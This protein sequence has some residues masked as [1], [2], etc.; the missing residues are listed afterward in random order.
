MYVAELLE[1]RVRQLLGFV[2]DQHRHLPLMAVQVPH[3]VVELAPGQG[4][5]PPGRHAE[6]VQYLR[7]EVGRMQRRLRQIHHRMPDRIQLRGQLA[8]RGGLAGANVARDDPEC[9][10]VHHDRQ[11]GRQLR[12]RP[13]GKEFGG[14][15]LFGERHAGERE[16]R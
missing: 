16:G 6:R 1:R 12:E 2:T 15:D 4:P 13:A 8:D 14:R 10:G 5:A 11:A 9:S 7:V 3:E